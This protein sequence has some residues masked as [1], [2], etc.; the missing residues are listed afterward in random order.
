MNLKL[1]FSGGR[2]LVLDLPD[3]SGVG[4]YQYESEISISWGI[5]LP[6]SVPP[7]LPEL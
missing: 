1:L 4:I 3:L 5:D 7:G 2:D 6:L